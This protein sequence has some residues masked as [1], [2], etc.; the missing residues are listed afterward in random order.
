MVFEF[1]I[2]YLLI[3]DFLTYKRFNFQL[4]LISWLFNP[5]GAS[6]QIKY[7][8]RVLLKLCLWLYTNHLLWLGLKWNT[9]LAICLASRNQ[10]FFLWFWVSIVVVGCYLFSFGWLSVVCVPPT[11]Q[12]VDLCTHFL[13]PFIII[14]THTQYIFRVF[15]QHFL[16]LFWKKT[17]ILFCIRIT[18]RGMESTK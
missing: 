6:D 2:T 14:S 15:I 8:G 4:E 3:N 11:F 12:S 7:Q 18:C 17:M 9:P 5:Y 10:R 16:L 13:F 1:L